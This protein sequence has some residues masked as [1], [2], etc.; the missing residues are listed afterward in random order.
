MVGLGMPEIL[1]LLLLGYGGGSADLVSVLNPEAYFNSRGIEINL[2]KMTELA[3]KDPVDGKTQT[4]Q[5]LA[6][7]YLQDHAAD[8][9]KH[10]ERD[11]IV[12]LLQQIAQGKRSQD[13]LGFA[14]DAARRA[15]ARV[16]GKEIPS[17]TLPENSARGDALSWFPADSSLV[18]SLDGRGLQFP[19]TAKHKL[20]S[21]PLPIPGVQEELY[22]FAERVG[23]VRIDRVSFAYAEVPQNTN[24]SRIYIRFSGKVDHRRLSKYLQD[25]HGLKVQEKKGQRGENITIMEKSPPAWAIVGDT[26]LILAGYPNQHQGKDHE[27][28]E[29]ALALYAGKGLAA[30]NGLL[31]GELQ[32]ISP[33]AA[34]LLVGELPPELRKGFAQGAQPFLASPRRVTCDIT[35]GQNRLDLRFA[36]VFDTPA[37]AQTFTAHVLKLKNDGIKLVKELPE[38]VAPKEKKDSLLKVL[39]S[40]TATANAVNGNAQVA[41]PI[42]TIRQWAEVVLPKQ[43]LPAPNN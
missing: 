3:G 42:E 31:K 24:Q 22:K 5:L 8:V 43:A 7:G 19:G 35:R 11:R 10:K 15:L 2:P 29:E 23:N 12:E 33:K 26:D 18:G 39:D 21:I 20:S 1:I 27:V 16:Q 30:T 13:R 37:D 34:A 9:K 38:Q 32:K 41:V 40:I 28:L 4:A 25:D 6:I 14:K 36:G 17:L